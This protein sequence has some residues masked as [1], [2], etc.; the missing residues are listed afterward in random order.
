MLFFFFLITFQ[1]SQCDSR[2]WAA[3][4]ALAA[5]LVGLDLTNTAMS[6][7]EEADVVHLYTALHAMNKAPSGYKMVFIYFV[8][9]N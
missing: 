5:Y 7:T 9:Y 3:V 6:A 4:D 1:T 8:H 2:G